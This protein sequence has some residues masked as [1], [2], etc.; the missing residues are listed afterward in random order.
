MDIKRVRLYQLIKHKLADAEIAQIV[1]VAEANPTAFRERLLSKWSLG[2]DYRLEALPLI[3]IP[4][5]DAL[6]DII[7]GSECVPNE[8]QQ[9]KFLSTDLCVARRGWRQLHLLTV[10][11]K[12]AQARDI[13]A[14]AALAQK[15]QAYFSDLVVASARL[16]PLLQSKRLDIICLGS[17]VPVEEDLTAQCLTYRNGH[18]WIASIPFDTAHS[19]NQTAF[20]LA[21]WF[22]PE[23]SESI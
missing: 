9:R 23:T 7:R 4:M 21:D 14:M 5:R 10:Q 1:A 6:A 17:P 19:T 20:L 3:R 2:L 11:A 22:P 18:G 16:R 12:T 13:F 8:A 15:D